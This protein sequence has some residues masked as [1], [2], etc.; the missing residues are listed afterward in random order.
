VR[1]LR[2]RECVGADGTWNLS[3]PGS[4]LAYVCLTTSL[5]ILCGLWDSRG[6]VTK[7][8]GK[9]NV[10]LCDD[11]S[12]SPLGAKLNPCFRSLIAFLICIPHRCV[13]CPCIHIVTQSQLHRVSATPARP[14][15]SDE[16]GR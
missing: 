4:P 8:C 9:T 13:L 16:H 10:A 7:R 6:D 15:R 5:C 12:H 3:F 1:L 11:Y 2:R 14:V